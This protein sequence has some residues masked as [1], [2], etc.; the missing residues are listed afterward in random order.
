MNLPNLLSL[1]RL[2]LSPLML[3]LD[4]YKALVLFV[5][6]STTDAI[7]GYIARKFK[8]ETNLGMI[9]DP[10]AD[11]IL[12]LTAL[13]VFTYKFYI[14]PPNLLFVL[15]LR[16][17]LI[18]LGSI[19]ISLIKKTI[20][21]SRPLGKLTTAYICVVIPF[22]VLFNIKI[23][24]YVAYFLLVLSFFDYLMVYLRLMNSK[25]EFTPNP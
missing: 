20:P 13:Y 10:L 5:V 6:L 4:F 7:D 12:I 18:L 15:F 3:F 24:L 22:V 1:T 19:H 2:L 14:I 17:V 8:Q 16:D 11:K 25:A 23:T 9:L 21:K